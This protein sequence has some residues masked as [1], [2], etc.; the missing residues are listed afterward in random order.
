MSGPAVR[1][2]PANAFRCMARAAF[3]AALLASSLPALAEDGMGAV[4]DPSAAQI[5]AI[6]GSWRGLGMVDS[7]SSQA[8]RDG[9]AALPGAV[10]V[11]RRNMSERHATTL[12]AA[13]RV[14]PGILAGGR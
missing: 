5:T 1:P 9:A 2:F 7:N 8:G 12:P 4:R 3:A 14:V 6:G 11:T 10:T 13:L